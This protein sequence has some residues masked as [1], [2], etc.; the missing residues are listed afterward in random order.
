MKK[1]IITVINHFKV[2]SFVTKLTINQIIVNYV[3]LFGNIAN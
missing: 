3:I 1:K 2:E